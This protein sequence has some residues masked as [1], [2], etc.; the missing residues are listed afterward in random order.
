MPLIIETIY[1]NGVLKLLT[2]LNLKE[3]QRYR[4]M[5]LDTSPTQPLPHEPITATLAKRTTTL[6][7]GQRIMNLL[8][9]FQTRN[10]PDLSYEHIEATLDEF[11]QEQAR[12]WQETQERPQNS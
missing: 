11:R 8:G 1:E 10:L 6:R 2:R 12:E 5:L 9:I 7:N 4:L 3:H